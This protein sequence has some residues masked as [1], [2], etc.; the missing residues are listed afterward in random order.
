MEPNP[1]QVTVGSHSLPRGGDLM[2]DCGWGMVLNYL[3]R[4]EVMR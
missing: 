3:P 2:A 4:E 1:G